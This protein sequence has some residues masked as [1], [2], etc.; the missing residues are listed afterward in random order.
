MKRTKTKA[1]KAEREVLRFMSAAAT[2]YASCA[3]AGLAD[4]TEIEIGDAEERVL[5]DLARELRAR[6]EGGTHTKRSK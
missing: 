4:G 3:G 1:T 6:A 5:L 2:E